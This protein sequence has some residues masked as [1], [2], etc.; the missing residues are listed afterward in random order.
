MFYLFKYPLHFVKKSI[1]FWYYVYALLSHTLLHNIQIILR[2]NAILSN[3]L[4]FNTL[5]HNK[6]LILHLLILSSTMPSP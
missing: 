2:F 3:V 1:N 5:L 4:L 6:I